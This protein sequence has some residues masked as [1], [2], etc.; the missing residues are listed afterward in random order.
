[1]KELDDLTEIERKILE[2]CSKANSRT[3]ASHVP[4]EYIL[5]KHGE[6]LM[7]FKKKALNVLLT[8]GFI[9]K[10]KAGRS[11]DTYGLTRKG[12]MAINEIERNS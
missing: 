2:S 5:K 8:N 3:L 7:K 6:V 1:M 4:K 11:K 9:C 10:K 12:L